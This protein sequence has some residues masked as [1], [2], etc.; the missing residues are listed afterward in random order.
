V[1][2]ALWLWLLA[3]QLISMNESILHLQLYTNYFTN[4]ITRCIRPRYL[5]TRAVVV[6]LQQVNNKPICHSSSLVAF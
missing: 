5:T 6:L 2:V 3:D 1:A 4:S